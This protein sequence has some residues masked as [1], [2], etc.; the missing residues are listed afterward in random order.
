MQNSNE[1]VRF[2]DFPTEK[3]EL[4]FNKITTQLIEQ[5]ALGI[6]LIGSLAAGDAKEDSDIDIF[7]IR[8]NI[9]ADGE[10]KIID[11]VE[12]QIL[13]RTPKYLDKALDMKN[14]SAAMLRYNKI[15]YDPEGILKKAQEKLE[16]KFAGSYPIDEDEIIALRIFLTALPEEMASIRQ[17]YYFFNYIFYNRIQRLIS[18]FYELKRLWKPRPKYIIKE[19]K[20]IDEEFYE[21]ILKAYEISDIEDKIELI[22]KISHKCLDLT[23]GPLSEG[24]YKIF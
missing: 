20:K 15:V 24:L 9:P 2:T 1:K 12:V 23:D 19:L 6:L 16:T 18:D 8:E 21:L 7:V 14:V 3:H 17:D 4:A 22:E 5:E 11:G 13:W 10:H